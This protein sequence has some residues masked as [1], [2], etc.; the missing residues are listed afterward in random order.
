MASGLPAVP[1]VMDAH[2]HDTLGE[3]YSG[4]A[5]NRASRVEERVDRGGGGRARGDRRGRGVGLRGRQL[6]GPAGGAPGAAGMATDRVGHC[7]VKYG[8]AVTAT[9]E[10]ICLKYNRRNCV[11]LVNCG[12]LCSEFNVFFL[13]AQ[14]PDKGRIR[15]LHHWEVRN[16]ASLCNH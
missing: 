14:G 9:G 5:G 11:R 4:A 12:L 10:K 8:M 2:Y 7:P 16:E 13:C 3:A 1:V 6:P 15:V